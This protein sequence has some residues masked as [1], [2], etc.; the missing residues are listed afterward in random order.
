MR[1]I[2]E[3]AWSEIDHKYRYVRSRNGLKFPDHIHNGFY[4]LSAYLQTAASQAEYLC[5]M[6]EVHN[7]KQGATIKTKA[8]IQCGDEFT[9]ND[10]KMLETFREFS[11]QK[12]ATD[13]ED[14]LG[15]K[16]SLRTLIYIEKRLDKLNFEE[17][18]AKTLQQLFVKNRLKEFESIHQ[19]IFNVAPFVNAKGRSV[20]LINALNF[21]IFL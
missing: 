8:S 13:L 19:E 20:D 12:I 21:S 9:A 17:T 15:F 2:L 5:R 11:T 16:A 1:T 7:F 4:N 18:Q 14:I 6:A 3:E 10:K